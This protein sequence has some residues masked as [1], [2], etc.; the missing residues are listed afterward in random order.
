MPMQHTLE[1][2]RGGAQ[3]EWYW[4]IYKS[5]SM[6]FEIERLHKKHGPVIRIGVND[7][8]INDPEFYLGVTR[9]AS[10]FLKDPAFYQTVGFPHAILGMIDPTEHRIRKQV[11][12]PAFAGGQIQQFSPRIEARVEDMCNILS[13]F[14]QSSTPV[15]IFAALKAYSMDVI[16]DVIIGEEFGALRSPGFRHPN[17]DLMK[18]AI[19]GSWIPRAFPIMSR[20]T[21]ALPTWLTKVFLSVP[22]IEVAMTASSGVDQYL[23][24]REASR[25]QTRIS[26]AEQPC[27]QSSFVKNP[28]RKVSVA[29]E[30]LLDP[31]SARGYT[32]LCRDHLNEEILVLL[33]AGNDTTSNAIILG[34]YHIC[35]RPETQ[36]RLEAELEAAYPHSEQAVTFLTAKQLP[37]L[38]GQIQTA[39]IKESLRISNPLPGRM[40]RVV[41]EEGYLLY[42]HRL[43]SKVSAMDDY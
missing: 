40:P 24:D 38:H 19:K 16:Y 3:Y 31:A 13:E 10:N 6:I 32:P 5:G 9:P 41:P 22:M 27:T 26:E 12:A 36:R 43:A 30:R 4:N 33:G 34:L 25:L 15:N 35:R 23:E 21:F 2:F 42:G 39:V 11:L 18:E 8:H 14:A 7:L 28:K 1:L 17:L 20:L 29:I 37:Y